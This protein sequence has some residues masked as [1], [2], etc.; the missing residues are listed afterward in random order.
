LTTPDEDISKL[1]ETLKILFEENNRDIIGVLCDN[2]DV[3]L[4][5]YCNEHAVMNF[6]LK[7]DSHG[8]TPSNQNGVSLPKGSINNDFT[9]VMSTKNKEEKKTKKLHSPIPADVPKE[10]EQ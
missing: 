9:S 10:E 8:N 1:K 3:I 5:N 4:L 6:T 7:K 2:L